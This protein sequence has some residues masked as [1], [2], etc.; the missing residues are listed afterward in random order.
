[1]KKYLA[2]LAVAA[3]SL[4][5]ACGKASP[6]AEAKAIMNDMIKLVDTT[7]DKLDKAATGQEAADA[8]IAFSTGMKALTEKGKEFDKKNPNVNVESGE[9]FKAERDKMMQSMTKFTEVST[10]VMMKFKDSK[11]LLDAAQKM[12]Q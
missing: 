5:F 3:L 2:L 10:K 12:A 8:L 11:E 4:T 9:A 6:E 1:M 7:T